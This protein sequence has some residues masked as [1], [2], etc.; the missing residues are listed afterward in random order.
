MKEYT[1]TVF[2]GPSRSGAGYSAFCPLLPGLS[3]SARTRDEAIR[4]IRVALDRRLDR[5][6]ARGERIPSEPKGTR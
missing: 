1:Y 2:L 3:A 5:M 6:I 4:K